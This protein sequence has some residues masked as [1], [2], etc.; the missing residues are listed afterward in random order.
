[1]RH[2]LT[3]LLLLCSIGARAAAPVVERIDPPFWWAGMKNPRLQLMLYGP[4]IAD[5]KAQLRAPGV[6]LI[7]QRRGDSPNVLFVELQLA[8]GVKS[9]RFDIVLSDRAGTVTR[10]GYEL[11]ERRAGSGAR[12]GFSAR[13]VILNLVPDRFAN[14]DPANDDVPG[15][16]DPANRAD[17]GA[18]RHGGDI[19]GIVQHLD[20]IAGLGYT[21]LWPTPL[22]ENK[23]PKYSYHGYAIT[24]GYKVD[25]RFG[26]ND[27]YR[28]LAQAARERGLGVIQDIVLNHIG[29]G[30]H[31][32]ADLP[33]KDWLTMDG[34]YVP[35]RHARTAV[36]DPYAAPSDRENFMRGWFIADMPDLNQR[37]P[38]L[39][40]WLIQNTIW[41][42]EYA[43][44]AGV[45]AD[46]WGY[47]DRDFLAK[48][49]KAV[50][51][52]YPKLNIVGEEWSGNPVVVSYWQRGKK[53]PDGYVSQLP[54]LMD[55]PLHYVLRRALASDE[56]WNGGLNE[57]YEGLINDKLY[58]EPHNMVLFEG[59][60]DV[61]RLFSVFDEDVALTKMALA[62]VLTMRGIPQ[63]YYGTEVLMTSPKQ[64]DDGATRQDFPGGWAG[65]A[66]NARTG[67]GLS[68][69]QREVQAFV[70]TLMNWRKTAGVIHTGKLMHYA[71]ENGTYA[72]FR[73]DGSR[74]V[75]VVFN[76]N[77]TETALDT[78]RFAEVLT[79]QVSGSDVISGRRFDLASSVT[80]PP[81][82]VLVLELR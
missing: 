49:T 21:M 44:L 80:L 31:W 4:R 36:S 11:R 24:D 50:L 63:L 47:S 41:W 37:Q 75:M 14:G 33:T 59:N 66:V 17:L 72:F 23:Q 62:Y 35:T 6:Q 64:R 22:L 9:G 65:D 28:R 38:L 70:R 69:A 42:I 60:H 34:R 51:A 76:K 48:W 19:A 12:S 13:D 52:E 68:E 27:D 1:M 54:A 73:Y 56:S 3:L 77:K 18:G 20:Y 74:K 29:S 15:Y 57:L 39:A 25:P 8:P 58:P 16:P 7:G 67:A 53:N 2:V 61:P 55:F 40:T 26:S 10:H 32:L 81:R 78:R 5:A 46:T 43:E 30:H 45:R 71:P 82:S 79:G